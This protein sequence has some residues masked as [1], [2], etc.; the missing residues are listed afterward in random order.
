MSKR[1]LS[2]ASM[3]AAKRQQTE[4]QRRAQAYGH[5]WNQNKR[6]EAQGGHWNRHP[7][8]L[9]YGNG[10]QVAGCCVTACRP[11]D[12]SNGRMS[13]VP[14]ENGAAYVGP[15]GS[16]C[17]GLLIR[18]FTEGFA[19]DLLDHFFAALGNAGSLSRWQACCHT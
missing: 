9:V 2:G 7:A 18:M 5:N 1:E 14:Y 15:L 13:G 17:P 12:Y 6:Y 11:G 16:S 10:P 4:A 3:P 19:V 8:E